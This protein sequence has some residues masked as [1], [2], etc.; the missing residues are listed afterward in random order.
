MLL[1][2]P[3][4][5]FVPEKPEKSVQGGV[6]LP[7]TPPHHR[8]YPRPELTPATTTDHHILAVCR[9]WTPLPSLPSSDGIQVDRVHQSKSFL[10]SPQTSPSPRPPHTHQAEGN[11]DY[12]L[13]RTANRHCN[14]YAKPT[15]NHRLNLNL[16]IPCTPISYSFSS[17]IHPHTLLHV[18]PCQANPLTTPVRCLHRPIPQVQK[19]ALSH[20]FLRSRLP[21]PLSSKSKPL[22]P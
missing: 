4:I 13:L 9:S 19:L 10:S 18:R 17:I 12:E 1:R 16:N 14:T 20:L 15:D 6:V 5:I 2:P 7:T 3:S 11:Q 22:P 8:T 21:I